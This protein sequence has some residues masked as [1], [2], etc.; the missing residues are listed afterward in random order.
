MAR[1][2]TATMVRLVPSKTYLGRY[3][4]I[5]ERKITCEVRGEMATGEKVWVDVETGEQYFLTRM[6]GNYMFYKE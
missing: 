1:K 4:A 5:P 3:D 2:M 6:L